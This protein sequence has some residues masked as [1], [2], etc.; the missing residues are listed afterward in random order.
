MGGEEVEKK[1]TY[2]LN[3]SYNG[4]QRNMASTKGECVI[5]S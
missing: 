3:L 1:Y 5:K 2:F 4:K